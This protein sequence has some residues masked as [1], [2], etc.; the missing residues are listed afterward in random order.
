MV[1]LHTFDGFVKLWLHCTAVLVLQSYA[2]NLVLQYFSAVSD[3]ES[4]LI[5]ARLRKSRMDV[6]VRRVFGAEPGS[7]ELSTLE[8]N[9]TS[10]TTQD[11]RAHC[12]DQT[13]RI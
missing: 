3:Y 10:P 11:R 2:S 7:K 13:N 1:L 6:E 8:L 9:S 5:I 12:P 4:C